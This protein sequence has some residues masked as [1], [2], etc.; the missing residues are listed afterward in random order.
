MKEFSDDNFI[1][2]PYCEQIIKDAWDYGLDEYYQS[3]ECPY[4]EKEF[5][6]SVV[7]REFYY[8]KEIGDNL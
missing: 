3:I 6:A 8:S 5:K 1:I 4:C 2:C 7:T